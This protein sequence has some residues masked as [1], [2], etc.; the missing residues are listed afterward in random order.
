[1]PGGERFRAVRVDILSA[2]PLQGAV[3]L[4]C[5]LTLGKELAMSTPAKNEGDGAAGR[6]PPSAVGEA[7]AVLA[8]VPSYTKSA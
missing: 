6:G 5:S 4:G 8:L 1:M 7:D 3:R 2:E